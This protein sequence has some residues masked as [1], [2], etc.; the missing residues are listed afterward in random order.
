[1]PQVQQ[2]A[3]TPEGLGGRS[4]SAARYN[5]GPR[6]QAFGEVLSVSEGP[7][8][9]IVVPLPTKGRTGTYIHLPK[10]KQHKPG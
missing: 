4:R 7:T 6:V 10:V 5:V 3:N 2:E 9:A 8:G 1:M